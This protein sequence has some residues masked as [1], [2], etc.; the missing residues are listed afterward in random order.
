VSSETITDRIELEAAGLIGSGA[1]DAR[2][3]I[4]TPHAPPTT[5]KPEALHAAQIAM[6]TDP[7]TRWITDDDGHA[8]RFIPAHVAIRE[9]NKARA[10]LASKE[11]R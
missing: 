4:S 2:P 3:M 6:V 11:E 9:V 5:G 8:E 10:A 7:E 1:R